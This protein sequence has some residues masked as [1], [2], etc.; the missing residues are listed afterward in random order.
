MRKLEAEIKTN[1]HIYRLLKRDER[2]AI[3]EQHTKDKKLVSYEVFKIRIGKEKK[4]NDTVIPEREL[5]PR[6]KDF[7]VTAFSIS[8]LNDALSK[9]NKL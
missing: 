1:G 5:F 4:L 9:Y 3:Y 8:K 2:K 6:D 7:G